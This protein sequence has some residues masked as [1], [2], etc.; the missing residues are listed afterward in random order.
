[1]GT[2][3]FLLVPY[4]FNSKTAESVDY[5]QITNT[6]SIPSYISGLT[7][8]TNLLFD[9][10]YYSLTNLPVLFSG[11]Y[12]DLTNKPLNATPT[13]DGFMSAADKV[14][15]DNLENLNLTAGP[16]ILVNGTYPDL[17]LYNTASNGSHYLGEEYLGGIIFYLYKGSDGLQHGLV[18]SKTETSVY[19]QFTFTLTNADRTED[20][21]YN[22]GLMVYSNAK[23]WVQ[24]LGPEWYLPSIDELSLL[25]SNRF[26]VN[27]TARSIGS[28]LLITDANFWSS[29]EYNTNSA[30]YFSFLNGVSGCYGKNTNFTVRG[31]RAF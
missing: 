14:K 9:G 28:A 6:P 13:T 27:K 17:T 25:W 12:P 23:I 11:S 24:G 15:S 20:G 29:S 16:G 8:T 26:F 21:L 30:Y 22:T 19:W 2:S 10:D 5:L 7:D 1:M 18:V 3:Q 4:A 31:I